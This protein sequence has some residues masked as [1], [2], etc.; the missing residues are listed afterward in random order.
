MWYTITNHFT[1]FPWTS[2]KYA[3]FTILIGWGIAQYHVNRSHNVTDFTW[4]FLTNADSKLRRELCILLS[5]PSLLVSSFCSFLFNSVPSHDPVEN[6]QSCKTW[7][8]CNC[9]PTTK[10]R[11][12]R[13][14]SPKEN[15]PRDTDWL[16]K[17]TKPDTER[18]LE[19]QTAQANKARHRTTTKRHWLT[20]QAR[21]RTTTIDTDWQPKLT[22]PDTERSLHTAEAWWSLKTDWQPKLTT[23][24]D[25]DRQT[26]EAVK[27]RRSLKTQTDSRSWQS[28]TPNDH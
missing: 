6:V 16:P 7:Q 26:A 21:H 28:P 13:W 2:L 12:L 10:G 11:R 5:A 8:T 4:A 9:G 3:L 24:R 19:T 18:P 20:A 15:D 1:L 22:K 17:L 27:A 25:T 23:E 14:Q